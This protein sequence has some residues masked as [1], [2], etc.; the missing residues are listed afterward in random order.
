MLHLFY[1]LHY[2]RAFCNLFLHAANG[3]TLHSLNIAEENDSVQR[4]HRPHEI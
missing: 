2:M 1:K 3:A 4:I